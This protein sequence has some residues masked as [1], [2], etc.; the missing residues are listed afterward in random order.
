MLSKTEPFKVTMPAGFNVDA[1]QPPLLL[2]P[3]NE[4]KLNSQ[5]VS[6]DISFLRTVD[7]EENFAESHSS[8]AIDVD[9]HGWIFGTSWFLAGWLASDTVMGSFVSQVTRTR[10]TSNGRKLSFLVGTGYR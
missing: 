9:R 4:L 8:R 6:S 1:R 5:A 10:L 3:E 2:S 7:I